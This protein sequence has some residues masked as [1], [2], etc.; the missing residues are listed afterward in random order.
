MFN[1]LTGCTATIIV[2]CVALL[3]FLFFTQQVSKVGKTGS[4]KNALTPDTCFLTLLTF[5]LSDFLFLYYLHKVSYRVRLNFC[6][7]DGKGREFLL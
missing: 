7:K 6:F 1:F 5:G 3:C 2:P 4:P